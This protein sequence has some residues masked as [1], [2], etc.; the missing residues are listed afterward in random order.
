MRKKYLKLIKFRPVGDPPLDKVHCLVGM[1]VQ[2]GFANALLDR[3]VEV[4]CVVPKGPYGLCC[5]GGFRP[6]VL[7]GVDEAHC[8]QWRL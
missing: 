3:V 6:E 2:V 4:D 1:H 8:F 5:E 7:G